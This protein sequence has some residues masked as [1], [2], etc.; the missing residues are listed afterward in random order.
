MRIIGGVLEATSDIT[1]KITARIDLAKMTAIRD[2]NAEEEAGGDIDRPMSVER[3]F[4]L[5]FEDGDEIQFFADRGQDKADWCA[6]SCLCTTYPKLI[7]K[8]LPLC[9]LAHLNELLGRVP[10]LPLWSE[11]L[12]VKQQQQ[13]APAA[14]RTSQPPAWR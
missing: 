2:F 1:G 14:P 9:R 8:N 7:L 10:S 3:S 5:V 6:L 12:W 4:G 13:P 11:L